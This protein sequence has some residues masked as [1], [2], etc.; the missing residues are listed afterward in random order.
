MDALCGVLPTA[1]L[2]AR[3]NQPSLSTLARPRLL[4]TYH[5]PSGLFA[6]HPSQARAMYFPYSS[7][8]CGAHPLF[9]LPYRRRRSVM[10]AHLPSMGLPPMK[11]GRAGSIPDDVL[12]TTK[13]HSQALHSLL[14]EIG[15][16]VFYMNTSVV[17]L[18]AVEEG[19][20]KPDTLDVSWA[21]RNQKCAA[22]ETR[23][24]ILE[25]V[26]VRAS[27]TINQF[28]AAVSVLPSFEDVRKK[29]DSYTSVAERLTSVATAALDKDDYLIPAAVLL[30][31]WR[32]RVVHP[33]SNAKLAAR[34][35]RILLNNMDIISQEYRDLNVIRLLSHFDEQRPTLKDISCLI[36]MTINLA[37]KI[38]RTI[39]SNLSKPELEAW[40][41]HY[42]LRPMLK[43]IEAET[44][45][46]KYKASVCRHF[47]SRAPYLLESYLLHY[48]PDAPQSTSLD[49]HS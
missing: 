45:P 28:I 42:E 30:V 10:A 49:Q 12:S 18:H 48:D 37:R 38:D 7:L 47:K 26:M 36:A 11:A 6:K 35:K 21:P 16:A 44:S 43:K 25:S 29:W 13:V 9:P 27:E 41:D 39:Q 20:P 24:F 32:N 46:E 3:V 2:N 33:S 8:F 17:G 14:Q 1:Y 4:L 19:Y 5:R 22:R 15:P 34:Q 31:H 23:K 40:L